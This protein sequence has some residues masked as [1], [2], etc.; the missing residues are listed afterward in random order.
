METIEK[1]ELC[2]EDLGFGLK[3]Y[4][5]GEFNVVRCSKCGLGITNPRPSLTEIGRYYSDTYYSFIHEG[6]KGYFRQRIKELFSQGKRDRIFAFLFY[7]LKEKMKES[8]LPELGGNVKNNNLF[9]KL[10]YK[11]SSLF[12]EPM[13]F[14]PYIPDGKILDIG[15][16]SGKF[17]LRAKKGGW[18]AYG[19]EISEKAVDTALRVGLKVKR[20]DGTFDCIDFPDSH[21]DCI[22]MNH[23]LE[24]CHY[25]TKALKECYRLLKK[26]GL[27]IIVAP[28]LDCYDSKVFGSCWGNLEVPRHLFHFDKNTLTALIRKSGFFIERIKYKKW[29]I[30]YSEAINFRNLKRI[31]QNKGIIEKYTRLFDAYWKIKI[32]K[33]LL[34]PFLK[35]SDELL[36]QIIGVYARKR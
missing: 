6:E 1:C 11:V 34:M 17:L 35:D 8:L 21:F 25:P 32:K 33:K 7:K 20:T 23:T 26:D 14:I 18:D 13:V 36:G 5:L 22:V 10:L 29:F 3:L 31:L 2:G 28:N 24:H 15:C 12:L 16:G 9:K 19:L 27:L 30:S 4:S